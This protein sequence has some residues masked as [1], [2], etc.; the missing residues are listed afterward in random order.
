MLSWIQR[1][2]REAW[3]AVATQDLELWKSSSETGQGE[4]W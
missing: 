1:R 4:G 2:E 3:G